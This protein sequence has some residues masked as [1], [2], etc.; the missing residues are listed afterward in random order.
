M[1]DEE[2]EIP[3]RGNVVLLILVIC[4]QMAGACFLCNHVHAGGDAIFTFTLA[5]TPYEFNYIDNKLDK[6]PSENG[7]FSADILRE[8]YMAMPYNRFNYS[9]VYWHQRLDNHP[10]LYYS[11]VHTL[12]SL[13]PNSYSIWYALIINV[14]ALLMIDVI[15][16]RIGRLLF[17]ERYAGAI[18]ILTSMMMVVFYGMVSL[19]RMYMLL[20]LICLWFLYI[21]LRIVKEMQVSM[22]EIVLCVFL[23]SQTH[24]YFYVYT[25]VTGLIIL[26]ILLVKKR[27]K[28]LL[29]ILT[30]ASMGEFLSLILFPWVVWHIVFNQMDKNESLYVWSQQQVRDYICFINQ[31]VFNGRGSI[32]ICFTVMTALLAAFSGRKGCVHQ[33][34]AGVKSAWLVIA[35]GTLIYSVLIYTL[36]GAVD[37]YAMP[38]YLP[39]CI[40]MTSVVITFVRIAGELSLG[41]KRRTDPLAD[42]KSE[43]LRGAVSILLMALLTNGVVKLNDRFSYS[44]MDDRQ[45]CRMHQV[46]EEYRGADCLYVASAED[47]L[48]QNMWFEFGSYGKFKRLREVDYCRIVRNTKNGWNSILRGHDS[49]KP[50]VLYLPN[51]LELPDNARLIDETDDFLIAILNG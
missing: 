6:F 20:A 50:V 19:A 25:A 39:V 4:L 30:A 14:L 51:T 7:W 24:Y 45:Y 22:P 47:N 15:L 23:G 33:L 32:W 31:T 38:V 28:E 8:Q 34:A 35:P 27:W 2:E 26:M 16:I 10:L 5:N 36:N 48:L 21:S 3:K 29:K 9:G 46:A 37:Y 43:L 13:F 40:L 17:R 1:S 49:E 18:L 11:L 44:C 12:C 42:K 41:I